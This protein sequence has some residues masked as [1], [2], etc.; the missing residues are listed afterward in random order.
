M[1]VV[2]A[3]SASAHPHHALHRVA[4]ASTSGTDD[5]HE[6]RR[7]IAA[8]AV[9]SSSTVTVSKRC[10]RP[11]VA[12][13]RRASGTTAA[14]ASLRHALRQLRSGAK[15]RGGMRTRL[16]PRPERRRGGA[17]DAPRGDG[18]GDERVLVALR[19]QRRS[20]RNGFQ[21]TPWVGGGGKRTRRSLEGDCCHA[22][23]VSTGGSRAV[24]AVGPSRSVWSCDPETSSS[25]DGSGSIAGLLGVAATRFIGI[26]S[27]VDHKS[28]APETA[29][30]QSTPPS[31]VVR[32]EL[33]C[34][35]QTTGRGSPVSACAQC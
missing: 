4:R 29:P 34:S 30:P 16:H 11:V 31:A 19:V 23:R 22:A 35:R 13:M 7:V 28:I 6:T 9:D 12:R 25:S 8:T 33:S 17:D 15:R 14:V 20:S 3:T 26:H 5:A 18:D 27:V 1:I 10:S 21:P 2:S 32:E 24:A